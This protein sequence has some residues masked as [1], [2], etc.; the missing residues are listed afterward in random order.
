MGSITNTTTSRSSSSSLPCT[1][2][3][4]D[5]IVSWSRKP[6]FDVNRTVDA[7]SGLLP[8]HY[9]VEHAGLQENVDGLNFVLGITGLN[10]NAK[11]AYDGAMCP[12]TAMHLAV[13]ANKVRCLEILVATPDADINK[14]DDQRGRTPLYE[15]ALRG[16]IGCVEVLVAT[17]GVDV[18]KKDVKYGRTPLFE[19]ALQGH[20]GCMEVLLDSPAVDANITL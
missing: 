5:Q 18:N 19:A 6:C 15:A 11:A 2:P 4:F 1:L 8:L 7:S 10:V 13:S 3:I 14:Q 16:H 12:L 17:P 9:A 20:I